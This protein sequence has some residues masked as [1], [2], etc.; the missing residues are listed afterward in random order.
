MKE[1]MNKTLEEV[2]N[3]MG[4]LRADVIKIG[5][6]RGDRER[7]VHIELLKNN[8]R[9]EVLTN[10]KSWDEGKKYMDIWRFFQT[11]S[12][13]NKR[14]IQ[15][16]GRRKRERKQWILNIQWASYKRKSIAR[17]RRVN[18]MV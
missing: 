11:C 6:L 2:I 9:K 7:P 15:N 8:K 17:P 12:S 13:A 4:R 14:A 18:G 5:K 1:V 3:L 16:N 10:E